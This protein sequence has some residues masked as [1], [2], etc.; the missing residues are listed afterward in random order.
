MQEF[1]YTMKNFVAA[2]KVKKTLMLCY[3]F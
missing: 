2:F 1:I 3:W